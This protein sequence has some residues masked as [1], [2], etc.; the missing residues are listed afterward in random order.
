VENRIIRDEQYDE[1]FERVVGKYPHAEALVKDTL[2]EIVA[3]L[4]A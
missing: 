3:Y 2:L 1:L 4:D